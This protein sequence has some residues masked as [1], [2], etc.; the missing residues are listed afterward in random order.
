MQTQLL[1]KFNENGKFAAKKKKKFIFSCQKHGGGETYKMKMWINS[2]RRHKY[3]VALPLSL[4][5]YRIPNQYIWETEKLFIEKN[6]WNSVRLVFFVRPARSHTHIHVIWNEKNSY[7]IENESCEKMQEHAT[8]GEMI[9][10]SHC[11]QIEC[12]GIRILSKVPQFDFFWT[13]YG[14]CRQIRM[15]GRYNC[16]ARWKHPKLCVYVWLGAESKC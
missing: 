1:I 12:Q 14:N 3:I 8:F 16:V 6:K 4:S 11:E 15:F 9:L 13:F 5:I 7:T 10:D 2:R